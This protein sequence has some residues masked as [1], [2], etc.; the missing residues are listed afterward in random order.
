MPG[1]I[2]NR[3]IGLKMVKAFKWEVER[4]FVELNRT[5][6][7]ARFSD[8][9]NSAEFEVDDPNRIAY[10]ILVSL[11]LDKGPGA[12]MI[13]IPPELSEQVDL[14]EG[15]VPQVAD[16]VQSDRYSLVF[17]DDCDANDIANYLMACVEAFI[18]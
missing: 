17:L 5:W 18:G 3:D 2:A 1:R 11:S 8:E 7:D 6:L 13:S 14:P 10:S 4:R 12:W 16:G 9:N 15:A